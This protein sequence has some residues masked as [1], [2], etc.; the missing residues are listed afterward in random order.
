MSIN[1]LEGGRTAAPVAYNDRVS[2]VLCF[3]GY[4]IVCLLTNSRFAFF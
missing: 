3:F 1:W 2:V 4:K